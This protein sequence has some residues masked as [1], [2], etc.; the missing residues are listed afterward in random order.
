MDYA[1][2][3]VVE[4]LKETLSVMERFSMAREDTSSPHWTSS[5]SFSSSKG[6]PAKINLL[7]F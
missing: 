2:S 6:T 7:R 1:T 5:N 3:E 4:S